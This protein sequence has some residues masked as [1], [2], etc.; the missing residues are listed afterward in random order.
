LANGAGRNETRGEQDHKTDLRNA[1]IATLN[2]ARIEEEIRN[3]AYELF[4]ACGR[5]EGHE[6]ED[7]LRAEAEITGRKTGAAAA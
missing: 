5:E 3:R 2:P 7:W 4:E 1:P 6:L